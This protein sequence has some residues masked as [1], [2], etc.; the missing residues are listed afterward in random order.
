[1]FDEAISTAI[2]VP[3]EEPNRMISL[4]LKPLDFK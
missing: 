1:L 3:K 2:P 4:S